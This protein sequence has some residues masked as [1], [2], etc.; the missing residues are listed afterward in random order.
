MKITR[1]E[2]I[3]LRLPLRKPMAMGGRRYEEVETVLVRLETTGRH[4]GWARHPLP[5]F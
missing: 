2:A 5:R 3:P 4:P 1:A